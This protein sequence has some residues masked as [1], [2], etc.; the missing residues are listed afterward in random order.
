MTI[1]VARAVFASFRTASL[2]VAF[3]LGYSPGVLLCGGGRTRT[4][5]DACM[6][7]RSGS[8]PG[9]RTKSGFG[10]RRG[11]SLAKHAAL[12]AQPE[13][14][15]PKI[16]PTHSY[17]QRFSFEIRPGITCFESLHLTASR[18]NFVVKG[19][20]AEP[21]ELSRI[22]VRPAL[23]NQRTQPNMASRS[24]KSPGPVGFQPSVS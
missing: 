5:I 8:P 19:V 1:R 4:C 14:P 18:T 23:A 9:D 11:Y 2:A 17:A 7:L 10:S 15:R 24:V 6:L 12:E 20:P 21:L 3:P 16:V 13:P 22:A